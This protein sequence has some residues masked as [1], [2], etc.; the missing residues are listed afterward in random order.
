MTSNGNTGDHAGDDAPHAPSARRVSSPSSTFDLLVQATLERRH[1]R[2]TAPLLQ[3]GAGITQRAAR[4]TAEMI[5]CD[6]DL[7]LEADLA[8][9]RLYVEAL[10]VELDLYFAFDPDLEVDML[11]IY[12]DT[13]DL[14]DDPWFDNFDP[15][16]DAWPSSFDPEIAN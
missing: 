5:A 15:A 3:R 16:D 8:Q 12:G 2:G 6:P 13:D 10:E 4:E 11:V 14:L 1:A 9:P 7:Q